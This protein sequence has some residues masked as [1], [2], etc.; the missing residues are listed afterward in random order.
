LVI[1]IKSELCHDVGQMTSCAL[2]KMLS[3]NKSHHLTSAQ[4]AAQA[5]SAAAAAAAIEQ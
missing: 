4:R 3:A 2:Q 5:A 1:S